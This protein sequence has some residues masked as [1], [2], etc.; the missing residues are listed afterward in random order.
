[1]IV[2][3]KTKWRMNQ[4]KKLKRNSG[5]GKVESIVTGCKKIGITT[6]VVL[7]LLIS[8]SVLAAAPEQLATCAAC[9]GEDGNSTEATFPKLAGQTKEY[10]TK[11]LNNFISGK[12]KNDI[13]SPMASALKPNDIEALATY[14][15]SQ[16]LTPSSQQDQQLVE[17]GQKIFMEGIEA[18]DVPVCAGCHQA[19]AEGT[20]IYPRLAGQHADY[21]F[22]QLK[23]FSTAERSNDVSRFMRVVAKH[24]TEQ[25]MR[26]VAVYLSGL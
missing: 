6:S 13:M 18:S 1:M 8:G 11:Q 25:E 10:L 23:N 26:A 15:S 5:H 20:G 17:A 22:L 16:K 9:H 4:L 21:I 12:R 24:M 2:Y 3:S 14:F 19:N 7:G